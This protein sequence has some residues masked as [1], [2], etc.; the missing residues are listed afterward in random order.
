VQFYYVEQRGDEVVEAVTESNPTQGYTDEVPQQSWLMS[1]LGTLIPFVIIFIVFWFLIS[2]MS[3]GKMMKFGKS[4]AK[5]V[6]KE[7]PA[8]TFK[9]VA[10]VDEAVEELEEMQEFLA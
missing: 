3:G 5:I 4:K 7:N 10:G 1:L 2:Q 6:N 8:L 9:G